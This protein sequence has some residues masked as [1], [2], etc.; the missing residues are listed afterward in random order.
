M[1]ADKIDLFVRLARAYRQARQ[2][3]AAARTYQRL[4]K[5]F[6]NSAA[7]MNGLVTLAQIERRSLHDPKTA[8]V[9]FDLYLKKRPYGFLAEAARVGKVRALYTLGKWKSVKAAS[10]EYLQAHYG[11]LSTKEVQRKRDHA[12]RQLGD[13]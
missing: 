13:S 9:H 7:A 11:G 2:Y 6:P 1:P 4:G 8:I 3:E 10:D 12:V 5:A